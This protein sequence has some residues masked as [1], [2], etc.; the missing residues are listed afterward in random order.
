M[1]PVYMNYGMSY[2]DYWHGDPVMVKYYR[3]AYKLKLQEQNA[4]A[5]R[6]GAYFYEAIV[7]AIAGTFGK[8]KESYSDQPYPMSEEEAEAR[9]IAKEKAE[10]D[11]IK[12][13]MVQKMNAINKKRGD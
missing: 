4:F 5:H 11:K 13:Q 9:R 2:E 6:Q 10:Y 12:E 8:S 3:Q 1:C 7:K